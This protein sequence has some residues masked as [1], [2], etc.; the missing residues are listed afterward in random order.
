VR[1][2]NARVF[3]DVP[4]LHP[5]ALVLLYGIIQLPLVPISVRLPPGNFL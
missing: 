3:A 4:N 5:E 1:F 2:D